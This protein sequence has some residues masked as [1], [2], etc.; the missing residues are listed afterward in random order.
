MKK[1]RSARGG[2][3]LAMAT[4]L[5]AVFAAN[6]GV[7]MEDVKLSINAV[8]HK[9]YTVSRAPFK[10][11]KK[12]LDR[13]DPDWEKVKGLTRTFV[14]L[15]TALQKNEPTWG[16]KDSWTTF[17]KQHLDDAKGAGPRGQGQ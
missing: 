17:T 9:E 5:L 11:I 14:S 12:E 2:V 1:L 13:S 15:A 7:T 3:L 16:E 6:A 4:T 8:M 10:Q